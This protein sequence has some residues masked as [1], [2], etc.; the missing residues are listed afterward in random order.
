ME[1]ENQRL[2][3]EI[4]A[5]QMQRGAGPASWLQRVP[6]PGHLAQSDQAR[7]RGLEG[8]CMGNEAGVYVLSVL[9]Y[10]HLQVSMHLGSRGRVISALLLAASCLGVPYS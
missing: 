10:V 6:V 1:A 3:A 7:K 5:L 8:P 2:E 9:V 4:L